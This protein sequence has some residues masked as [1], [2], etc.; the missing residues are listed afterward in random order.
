M[1]VR[2]NVNSLIP[3]ELTRLKQAVATLRQ[4]SAQNPRTQLVG[5]PRPTSTATAVPTATGGSI[6]GTAPTSTI[7]SGSC[8]MPWATRPCSCPIGIGQ[9]SPSPFKNKQSQFQGHDPD[10]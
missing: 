6:P 8:K 2:R 3:V 9:E 4:R 5:W 10:R 1:A 7:S